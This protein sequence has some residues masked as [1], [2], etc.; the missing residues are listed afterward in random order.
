MTDDQAFRILDVATRTREKFPRL[1][2]DAAILYGCIFE[3]SDGGAFPIP[4]ESAR[5]LGLEML[6]WMGRRDN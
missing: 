2:A 1:T 3:L 5:E 4:E 6:N